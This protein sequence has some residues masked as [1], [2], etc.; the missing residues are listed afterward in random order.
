MGL[1]AT[2]V[3]GCV[4]PEVFLMGGGGDETHAAVL[5]R[6]VVDGEPERRGSS[7]V[8]RRPVRHVLMPGEHGVGLVGLFGEE[9][10][11]V[12]RHAIAAELPSDVGGAPLV[13]VSLPLREVRP[14]QHDVDDREV[15]WIAAVVA[16]HVAE[17]LA[18]HVDLAAQE[19]VVRDLDVGHLVV[20]EHTR[21]G[22]RSRFAR[23]RAVIVVDDVPAVAVELTHRSSS[24]S[25]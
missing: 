2:A 11:V 14:G 20:G 7:I 6:R 17:V 23:T 18:R 25:G 13:D 10:V 5:D 1:A 8:R 19:P 24:G 9:L 16:C 4:W 22:G 12:D 21:S 3:D 15:G